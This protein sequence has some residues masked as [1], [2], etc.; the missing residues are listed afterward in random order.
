MAATPGNQAF[1][2]DYEAKYD[3]DA[4]RRSAQSYAAL[5]I[6]AEAI[7]R[8]RSADASA[9]RDAM[10]DIRDSDTIL[11]RFSFDANGDAVYDPIVLIVRDGELAVFE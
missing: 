4:S 3:L 9:I 1:I 6:L 2:D 10:A 5:H 8:A 11:G 7:A